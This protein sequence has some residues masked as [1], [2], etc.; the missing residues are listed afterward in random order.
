M[1]GGKTLKRFIAEYF[2]DIEPFREADAGEG[3]V[4]PGDLPGDAVA[5]AD[6]DA[7]RLARGDGQAAFDQQAAGGNHMEV[8]DKLAA[9]AEKLA[10]AKMAGPVMTIRAARARAGD[11]PGKR[12]DGEFRSFVDFFLFQ[13]HATSPVISSGGLFRLKIII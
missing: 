3:A 13:S 8:A 9:T 10:G 6:F 1:A 4:G 7:D 2:Q 11:F 12:H 5:G